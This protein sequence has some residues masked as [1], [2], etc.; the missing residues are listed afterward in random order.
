MPFESTLFENPQDI[1]IRERVQQ[2]DYFTDLNLDQVIAAIT[3]GKD[4]YNLPPLFHV[5]LGDVEQV[6][7]RHEVLRDLA[8]NALLTAMKKFAEGMRTVRALLGHSSKVFYTYE[9]RRWFL[10][11]VGVY[12]DAVH[13]LRMALTL[14]GLESRGLRGLLEYLTEYTGS[15]RFLSL[16]EETRKL[17]QDLGGIRYSVLV[18]GPNVKVRRYDAE[19]D[20][21]ADVLTTFRKFQ[22][23]DVRD[24]RSEFRESDRMN[25]VE[26]RILSCVAELFPDIFLHLS[27]YYSKYSDFIDATIETFDREIQFYVSCLDYAAFFRANGLDFCLPAVSDRDKEVAVSQTFDA[28]L[29]RKLISDGTKVVRNDFFLS[30]RERI[31]VVSGPNQGGKTTFART[32]GQLHFLASLGCPVPGT[33]ARLFLFDNLFT[34][35]EKEELVADDHGKLEDDLLRIHH[36]FE[37]ATPSSVVIMNEIFNSTT[38]EDAIFLGERVMQRLVDLDLLGVCVTFIDE[39][40]TLSDK[41]VSMASTVVPDNPA[42]RTFKVIRK[43]ADGLAYAISLAVKY[44]LTYAE[45]KERLA[46]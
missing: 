20:Y 36:V 23:G 22:Q 13:Q 44:R 45:L 32:F 31:I 27:E 10:D 33:E 1:A 34:H 37:R 40:A 9:K 25:Q 17:Q 29:A 7:Y 42:Q 5:P 14:A 19:T 28:A 3:A 18:S 41:V 46:I 26:A 12:C 8:D 6:E 2:P 11:A 16:H 21:S 43:P 4:E 15:N 30:G 39:L 35:F 38:L 24:Y